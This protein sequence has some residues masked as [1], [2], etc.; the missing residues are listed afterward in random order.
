VAK[1]R[2]IQNT[3]KWTLSGTLDYDT[4]AW[5]G[6]LDMNTTVSYR[7]F[8]QQFEIA[9]PFLDQP[10]YALWDANLLWRSQGNRYEFGIHA[11]NINNKKYVVGGY[12]YLAG[13]PITGALTLVNGLP[14]PILGKTGIATGFY[15][16]PRQ[17][18]LS[19]AVNF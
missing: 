14:V 8:S 2:R 16:D 9:S 12:S 11:K 5:G 4:P 7:S 13:S 17:V 18:F 3:P 1:N 19:A 15:G 10:G 6:H